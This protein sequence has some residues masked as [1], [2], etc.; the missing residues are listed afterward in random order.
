MES[1]ILVNGDMFR[2]THISKMQN[3]HNM[4]NKDENFK[5]Y[6]LPITQGLSIEKK[7]KDNKYYVIAFIRWDMNDNH[8]IFEDVDFR[9]IYM[10]DSL[11]RKELDEYFNCV[12]FAKKTLEDVC[13]EEEE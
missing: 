5:I 2:V 3:I 10:L 8:P 12:E 9:S 4:I 7:I 6:T 11:T 1:N 13:G